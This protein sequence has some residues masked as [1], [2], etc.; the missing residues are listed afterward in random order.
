MSL[1]NHS[2][3]IGHFAKLVASTIGRFEKILNS[4]VPAYIGEMQWAPLLFGQNCNP[5]PATKRVVG[6]K[7]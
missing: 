7:E 2:N 3:T 1:D 4:R 5:Y 6:S